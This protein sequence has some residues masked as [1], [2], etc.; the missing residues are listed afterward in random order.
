MIHVGRLRLV[1]SEVESRLDRLDLLSA[2]LLTASS[3][4]NQFSAW[5]ADR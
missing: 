4:Q 3:P 1:V 5:L 2:G